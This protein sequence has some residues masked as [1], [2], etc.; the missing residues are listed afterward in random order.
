M[1]RREFDYQIADYAKGKP[2]EELPGVSFRKNGHIVNNPE[3]PAI[4][5][6][7]ELPWVTKTYKRDLDITRYNVPFLLNP[8]ISMYTS[9]GCPAHVHV[10]S[11]AADAFRPSLAA[12]FDATTWRNEVRYALEAVPADEGNLLRRRYLQ[13]PEGAHHRAVQ[14]AEAAEFHV[15]VHV[16]RDHRL[17]HAEGD[18]GSRAAGC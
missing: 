17:R 8:F 13:L 7:D 4:E 18:E 11:V 6:L 14:E 1:V 16:A 3:G 2:L 12:A 15:V 5:N 10:L 9:R